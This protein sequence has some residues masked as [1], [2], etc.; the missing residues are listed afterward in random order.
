[1]GEVRR[2]RKQT[3]QPIKYD[4][5][6]YSNRSCNWAVAFILSIFSSDERDLIHYVKVPSMCFSCSF[7]FFLVSLCA[8]DTCDTYTSIYIHK[9]IENC[10][11][12]GCFRSVYDEISQFFP[13]CHCIVGASYC[14]N[15]L[16]YFIHFFFEY[17]FQFSWISHVKFTYVMTQI[18]AGINIIGQIENSWITR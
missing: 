12:I 10:V 9:F 1:M 16:I 17:W 7:W 6:I 3:H 18:Q 14:L 8:C 11:W 15:W 4:I 5:Y 13:C 2:K